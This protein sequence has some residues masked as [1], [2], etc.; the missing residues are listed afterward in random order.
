M[1]KLLT[2]I[3]LLL[4]VSAA[5][6]QVVLEHT[7]SN[8]MVNVINLTSTYY[9]VVDDTNNQ[10]TIYKEDYSLYKTCSF[11]PPTGYKLS[12][13]NMSD[14]LFNNTVEL[15]FLVS[16]TKTS[17]EVYDNSY[18]TVKLY[19]ELG[20]VLF[21]FGSGALV[22]Y[23]PYKTVLGNTKIMVSR[24]KYTEA[25]SPIAYFNSEVYNLV[26]NY[27]G[28]APIKD[29]VKLKAFPNP[30]KSTVNLPYS[31]NTDIK[32]QMSIFNLAGQLIE[33]KQVDSSNDKILLNVSSYRTGIYIYECNGR[34][35]QFIVE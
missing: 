14:K 19:N 31:V 23:S 35:G 32:T 24:M 3:G 10:V 27:S 5:N 21:D 33:Q 6:A 34:S 16:Y 1:K 11:I 9:Y 4:T 17:Y 18:Y 26:G 7:F 29:D 22:T 28:I 2:I 30:S 8:A 15:E 13:V 12:S 20:S 25:T